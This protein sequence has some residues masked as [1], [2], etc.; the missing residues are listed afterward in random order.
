MPVPA[1]R[2]NSNENRE[3][4]AAKSDLIDKTVCQKRIFFCPFLSKDLVDNFGFL[5][6][7]FGLLV[8]KIGFLFEHFG[9]WVEKVN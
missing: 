9:L 6:D 5:I 7:N 1:H 3:Y 2:I 4:G 8:E